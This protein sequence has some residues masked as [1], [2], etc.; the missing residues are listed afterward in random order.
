MKSI[1]KEEEEQEGELRKAES[2]KA[3]AEKDYFNSN[4]K[5]RGYLARKVLGADEDAEAD[6]EP[7]DYI[8]VG[9]LKIKRDEF[10]VDNDRGEIA[11]T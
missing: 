9:D 1:I 7:K 8:Q 2:K 3:Q 5:H 6:E 10:Q 11:D 4:N